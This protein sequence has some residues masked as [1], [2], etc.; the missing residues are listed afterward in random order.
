MFP[1]SVPVQLKGQAVQELDRLSV[2]PST[3]D[4]LPLKMGKIGCPKTS[5]TKCQPTHCHI[6]QER[7][8]PLH[9]KRRIHLGIVQIH[10]E[11][12]K[13]QCELCDVQYLEG[14]RYQY[15]FQFNGYVLWDYYPTFF[16][17]TKQT[18]ILRFFGGFRSGAVG[19]S[20][21]GVLARL[22]GWLVPDVSRGLMGH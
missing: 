5:V 4:S 11:L 8:P 14:S 15:A 6:P 12:K 21:L 17:C 19:A 10:W 20:F 22:T 1:D 3:A 13:W 9:F 16:V 2:P 7:G 18:P